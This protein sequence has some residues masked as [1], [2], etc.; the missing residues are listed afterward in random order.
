[1][2]VT[3]IQNPFGWKLAF[4]SW[5]GSP[6]GSWMRG[7]LTAAHSLARLTAPHPAVPPVNRSGI[8]YSTGRL[9]SEII[10]SKGHAR[11]GDLEGHVIALPQHALWV[12]EGTRPHTIRP[13]SPGGKLRFYW[14]RKGSWVA[15]ARVS[16][17]GQSANP[18][19]KRAVE[20]VTP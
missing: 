19:L 6:V 2:S 15:L 8:N 1:M 16:H 9:V 11:N 13:L 7:R 4:Q 18:F 17:P 5:I 3:F 10:T 20:K 14:H 12:H